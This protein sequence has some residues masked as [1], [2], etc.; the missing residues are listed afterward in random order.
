[1]S[2]IKNPFARGYTNL[3]VVRSLLMTDRGDGELIRK[4]SHPD[5]DG[6]PD[7]G[8]VRAPCRFNQDFARIIDEEDEEDGAAERD[9]LY[10]GEGFVVAVIHAVF[11]DDLD[12]RPVHVGDFHSPEA[13][14]DA[15]R[16]LR[17]ETGFY[18]RAWEISSAHLSEAGERY[19]SRLAEGIIPPILPYL[20]FRLPDGPLGVKLIATPWTEANLMDVFGIRFEDLHREFRERDVPDDLVLVLEQAG[21]ADVR[22]LIFDGDAPV[23]D[24]LPVHQ[25]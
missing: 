5:Q 21:R 4:P 2:S 12:G 18:S 11:G 13:A 3:R 23:L 22:L 14:R 20:V 9:A 25:E 1:M 17:F 10:P 8:L 19:L 15:V 16:R 6:L 7:D 24:G